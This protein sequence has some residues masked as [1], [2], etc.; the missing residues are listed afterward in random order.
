MMML[1]LL[2]LLAVTTIVAVLYWRKGVVE[3]TEERCPDPVPVVKPQ[4]ARSKER[5]RRG[6]DPFKGVKGRKMLEKLDV[7]RSVSSSS[8]EEH[9]T[10]MMTP[11]PPSEPDL[12]ES[13]S[14][15]VD[16]PIEFPTLNSTPEQLLEEARQREEQ[17]R[18]SL[19]RYE[20]MMQWE[21]E[22]WRRREAEMQAQIQQ[23]MYQMQAYA[24]LVTPY[25]GPW[26][27]LERGRRRRRDEQEDD[28]EDVSEL[29][30]DAILKRPERIIRKRKDMPQ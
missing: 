9:D 4:S 16:E 12:E 8:R 30:V 14:D 6:K 5:R 2:L 23:L 26:Y 3:G 10:P 29:L 25:I 20:E 27:P 28:D 19:Q 13:P 15:V 17:A 21:R 7:A 1:L 22:G 18:E 24:A 11:L